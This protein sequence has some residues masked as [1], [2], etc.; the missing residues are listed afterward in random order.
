MAIRAN[1]LALDFD[2]ITDFVIKTRDDIN[3]YIK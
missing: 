2:N 3:S 1:I